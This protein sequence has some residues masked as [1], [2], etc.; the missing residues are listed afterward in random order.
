MIAF[1]GPKQFVALCESV[2][3]SQQPLI[4]FFV[5]ITVF[6]PNVIDFFCISLNDTAYMKVKV[7][8]LTDTFRNVK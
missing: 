7:R 8:K 3:V 6:S 2:R 1:E 4:R 5:W